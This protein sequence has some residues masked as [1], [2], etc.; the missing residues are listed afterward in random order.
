[1]TL[2]REKIL[3]HAGVFKTRVVH[4]PGWADESGEDSVLVRGMTVR[5]FEVNQASSG[6]D[7]GH[8]T[9]ALIARCVVDENGGR[10]FE[11]KDIP[12][13]AELGLA[14]IGEIAK[15]ITDESGITIPDK[16]EAVEGDES[17]A[18]AP[19]SVEDQGKESGTHSAGTDSGLRTVS[20]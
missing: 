18:E 19:E 14:Q 5:E 2:S 13:I 20:A 17:G 11:D 4:V 10:V 9:A 6:K 15:A 12:Q 16:D 7:E 8:A 3:K 1:M